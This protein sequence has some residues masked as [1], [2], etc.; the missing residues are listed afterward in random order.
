VYSHHKIM[1]LRH[2]QSV[3]QVYLGQPVPDI[4]PP[5]NMISTALQQN[6]YS[7]RLCCGSVGFPFSVSHR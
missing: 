2:T 4:H 5:T 1:S 6:P 3:C 7:L